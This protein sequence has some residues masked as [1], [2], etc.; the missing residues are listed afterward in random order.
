MDTM[1]SSERAATILAQLQAQRNEIN[2]AGMARFGIN[3]E[4]AYGVTVAVLRG[5]AKDIRRDPALARV[6]WGSRVHEARILACLIHD[7]AAVA[8]EELDAMVEAID[9]WDLCDQFTNNVVRRTTGARQTARRWLT[10]EAPFV[11]RAGLSLLAS[12]AVHDKTAPN[13][14]FEADLQAVAAVAHDD[15]QPVKKAVSWALRQIGKRN[16]PLRQAAVATTESL[17]AADDRRSRWAARDARRELTRP[18]VMD[19][20]MA[21][22]RKPPCGR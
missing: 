13:A 2:R 19:R 7:P 22:S 8:T 1:A 14:E 18:E 21:K 20:A 16:E 3:V 9:S 15:R 17:L 6:L 11:K 5:L 10:S 4:R 12:L